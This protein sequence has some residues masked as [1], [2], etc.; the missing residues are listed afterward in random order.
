MN[1]VHIYR[2]PDKP[3]VAVEVGHSWPGFWLSIFWLAHRRLWREAISAIA[4]GLALSLVGHF[5]FGSDNFRNSIY[6]ACWIFALS[7]IIGR[8]GNA[9][10]EKKLRAEGY[11]LSSDQAGFA[12]SEPPGPPSRGLRS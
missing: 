4:L 11:R 3:P 7:I 12:G 2:H 10:I 5:L 6:Y 8:R 1:K 9:W